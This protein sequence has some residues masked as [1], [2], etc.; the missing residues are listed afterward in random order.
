MSARKHMAKYLIPGSFFPE[1]ETRRL[2]ERSVEAAVAAAPEGAYCFT[3]YDV[4]VPDFE[5]PPEFTL[6]PKALDKSLGRYYL[7]GVVY[8][9]EELRVLAAQEG[10]PRRYDVLIANVEQDEGKAIRCRPGNWQPF[11]SCDEI[12][13]VA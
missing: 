12:V 13:D 2:P 8:T 3:F 4:A 10:D 5:V 11:M 1:E 9:V 7:G 6:I